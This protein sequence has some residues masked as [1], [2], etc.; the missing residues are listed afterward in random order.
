MK[1][2][3]NKEENINTP[4]IIKSDINNNLDLKKRIKNRKNL[5]LYIGAFM[6]LINYN[7]KNHFKNTAESQI[8][9][10]S[11]NYNPYSQNLE[12]RLQDKRYYKILSIESKYDN[13]IL[14]LNIFN[15]ALA[16]VLC[17]LVS[18]YDLMIWSILIVLCILPFPNIALII[19]SSKFT[20]KKEYKQ[21]LNLTD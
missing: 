17:S 5:C 19:A 11:K 1:N 9:S 16:L 12:Q 15:V 13:Y 2:S 6:L 3:E 21:L 4:N 18:K 14:F 20:L 10:L 8:E 7:L